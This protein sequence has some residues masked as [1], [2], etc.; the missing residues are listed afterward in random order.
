ME[1]GGLGPNYLLGA[2]EKGPQERLRSQANGPDCQTIHILDSKTKKWN[3]NKFYFHLHKNVAWVI[4]ISDL[5]MPT[6]CV[7]TYGQTN[8]YIF[9][10]VSK[11]INSDIIFTLN[12]T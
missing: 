12:I 6:V 3:F 10:E 8:G 9:L 1:F 2:M 5:Q 7:I 4:L 11:V